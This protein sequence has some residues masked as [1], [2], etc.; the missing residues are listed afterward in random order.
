MKILAHRGLSASFPENTAIAFQQAAK[1]SCW[2]VEF[3]V[4]LT[5]DQHLVVIHDESIDRTSNGTGFVKDLTLAELKTYDFGSW[6]EEKFAGEQIC[7]LEEV[8]DIFK[9]TKHQINIEIKSDV[10][11][12]PGIEILVA[13]AIEK[14]QQKERI[15]VSSFNHE[16]IARFQQ[17]QP[18]INC[19][20]L[21]ASL[22]TNLDEYV[23]NFDCQAIHIP[24][25]Y[26]MRSIIQLAIQRGIIVRAYTVNNQKIAQ[27]ME[28]LGIDA[29]FS[30]KGIL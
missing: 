28:Q 16:T 12:Y 24:Y 14:F 18:N 29:I 3:D 8:L 11:E 1:L 19:A 6:F 30:D 27:Q 22:I 5:K 10:F 9:D 21:F 20:L 26:G 23:R 13:N 17:I 2:G 15:I 4:H 7:T 25:Y